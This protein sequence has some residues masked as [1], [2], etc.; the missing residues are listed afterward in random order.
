MKKF[1]IDIDTRSSG[2]FIAP[3]VQDKNH[4]YVISFKNRFEAD[5]FLRKLIATLVSPPPRNYSISEVIKDH[6]GQELI[7]YVC[8]LGEK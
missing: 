3:S 7:V 4:P 1:Y 8:D 2:I 6:R 5:N